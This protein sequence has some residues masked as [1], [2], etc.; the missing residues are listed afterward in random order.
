MKVLKHLAITAVAS[1]STFAFSQQFTYFSYQE[2]GYAGRMLA[3]NE[4]A[5]GNPVEP[6]ALH[7]QTVDTNTHHQC[8]VWAME[9]TV[10]RIKSNGEISTSMRV[11]DE[12]KR[13]TGEIFDV[14]FGKSTAVVTSSTPSEY[15]GVSAMFSGHWVRTPEDA[16]P[17]SE[18][19]AL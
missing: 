16:A 7:I 8:D 11:V 10:A 18:Q 15:C 3:A 19:D 12:N 5:S 4:L 1:F 13:A 2:G 9:N 14:V 17:E 6:I